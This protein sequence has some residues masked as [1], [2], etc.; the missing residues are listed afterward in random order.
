MAS[1][2][3]FTCTNWVAFCKTTNCVGLIGVCHMVYD[4]LCKAIANKSLQRNNDNTRG[5]RGKKFLLELEVFNSPFFQATTCCIGDCGQP[6]RTYH[7]RRDLH[8]F[9]FYNMFHSWHILR[10]MCIHSW[11]QITLESEI[12]WSGV[13][14]SW[15]QRK[16]KVVGDNAITK[17]WLKHW[18]NT[19]VEI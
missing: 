5:E 13:K 9:T 3:F 4:C 19:L 1:T 14:K 8:N 15:W 6:C 2:I 10:T 17:V 18:S 11:Y 7:N 16:F 12:H